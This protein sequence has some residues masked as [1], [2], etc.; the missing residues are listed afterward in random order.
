M[1]IIKIVF[2]LAPFPVKFKILVRA[3]TVLALQETIL[4]VK[5]DDI[6]YLRDPRHRLWECL[7]ASWH[8]HC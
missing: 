2:Y 4:H 5:N 1:K 7:L 8:L 3:K 6:K